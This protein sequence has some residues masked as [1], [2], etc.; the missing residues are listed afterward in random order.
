L[1][2][3][4]E[5]LRTQCKGVAWEIDVCLIYDQIAAFERGDFA[6]IARDTPSAIEEAFGRGRNWVG[7][8]LSS[9]FGSPARLVHDD[10]SGARKQLDEARKRWGERSEMHW[11]ECF[12]AMGEA[13]HGLYRREPEAS[14]VSFEQQ[15]PAFQ[16]S[17]LSRAAMPRTRFISIRGGSALA[18]LRNRPGAFEARRIV[19]IC[20]AKLRRESLAHGEPH[21]ELLEAG[22]AIIDGRRERA[23][24]LLHHAMQ[25]FERCDMRAYAAATR[26]RLGQL[27]GGEH[28]RALES[29]ADD[30]LRGAAKNLEAMT[31]MLCPGC[32]VS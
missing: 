1:A 26:R 30:V 5:L 4:L 27:Q 20:A 13:L 10:V 19:E 24:L 2:T 7:T 8:L 17:L 29:A 9:V 25:R 3:T 18:A 32:W 14:Y 15:T 12:L 11:A 22:L 31:E 21:A 16:R 28:G 23:A 6:E